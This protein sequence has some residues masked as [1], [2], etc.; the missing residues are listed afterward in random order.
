MQP[1]TNRPNE[2]LPSII[3]TK[4]PFDLND[5]IKNSDV[6]RRS[7]ETNMGLRAR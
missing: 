6:I 3:K 7:N 4:S 5:E 1:A 2:N